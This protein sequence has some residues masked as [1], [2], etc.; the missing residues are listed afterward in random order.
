M[1]RVLCPEV[2]DW[3]WESACAPEMEGCFPGCVSLA[4]SLDKEAGAK[5]MGHQEKRWFLTSG[6]LLTLLR[7]QQ[8]SIDATDGEARQRTMGCPLEGFQVPKQGLESSENPQ[9]MLARWPR[10]W[11]PSS[12][13]TGQLIWR[14]YGPAPPKV[15]VLSEFIHH[16]FQWPQKQTKRHQ[17]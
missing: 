16:T 8:E 7:K 5:R 3:V 4:V 17:G 14:S 13:L 9:F 12:A 1:D 2:E 11:P 10:Q 15:P 6:F